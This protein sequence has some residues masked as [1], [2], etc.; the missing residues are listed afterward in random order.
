MDDINNIKINDNPKEDS[1]INN[2]K[3][4]E[5]KDLKNIDNQIIIENNQNKDYKAN[6]N[7]RDINNGNKEEIPIDKGVLENKEKVEKTNFNIKNNNELN[8]NDFKE[9]IHIKDQ[10]DKDENND[11]KQENQT[12]GDERTKNVELQNDEK[13]V[14]KQIEDE[15]NNRIQ[16]QKEKFDSVKQENINENIDKIIQQ[17]NDIVPKEKNTVNDENSKKEKEDLTL[18]NFNSNSDL[19][20]GIPKINYEDEEENQKIFEEMKYLKPSELFNQDKQKENDN[21]NEL[22][23]KILENEEEIKKKEKEQEEIEKK[24]NEESNILKFF[25]KEEK[26]RRIK[27]LEQYSKNTDSLLESI[28]NDWSSGD[29]NGFTTRYE[30]KYINDMNNLFNKMNEDISI[31]DE[32]I[33]K[34]FKFICDYLQNRKSII[35]EIPWVE[36]NN[37][38]KI[39]VRDNFEGVCILNNDNLLIKQYEELLFCYNIENSNEKILEYNNNIF[40]KYLMEFLFKTGFFESFLEKVYSR[41]DEIYYSIDENSIPNEFSSF[42]DDFINL[43]C[44]PFEVFNYCT[45]EYLIKN[46]YCQKFIQKFIM[47]IESIIK[48][49]ALN[50]E[51]KKKFYNAITEK[52]RAFIGNFF[53]YFDDIK[54]KNNSDWEKFAC[55]VLII[56]ENYLTKQKLESRIYGLN[57]VSQLTDVFKHENNS[58]E[59]AK[60][61]SFVK[62][63][64]IKY[65]NKINIYNLIFGENIHEALVHRAYNL[66][67]FLYKNKAFNK[68][69]IKHLWILS[70]DK[71]QTISDNIIELFGKLLPEFS[72]DDSNEILKI[73]SEMN[74]SEVNEV[75]LKLLENFFNS[76]EK[77]EKLYKILFKFSDELTLNDGLSKSIILKSRNILVKLLFNQIYIK[78][79]INTIKKCIFNI[80]KNYLVN[81]SLSILK[82]IIDEFHRNENSQG[83]RI[84]FSEINPNIFSLDLLI[85]FLEKKGNLF[86]VLFTNILDNIYLIQFLLE[87]TKNLNHLLNSNENFD[88]ELSLKLDEMYKKFIDPENGYYYN[89]GLNGHIQGQIINVNPIR[90]LSNNQLDKTQSTEKSLNEGL[91]GDED[92]NDGNNQNIINNNEDIFNN[93]MGNWEFEINP[94]KYFKNIFKEY[95]LF[96][97]KVSKKNNFVFFS[98]KELI[99]YIF[100]KFEFPFNNKNHYQNLKELLDIIISFFVLGKIPIQIGY[101]KYLYDILINCSVTNQ[102][103]II[104]YKFLNDILKKQSENQNILIISDKVLTE[105][106]LDKLQK[107]DSSSINQLPYEAFEFFKLFIIY[108]NQKH[109]NIYYS[110]ATKKIVSIQKY[111]LLAGI[112]ILENYYIYSKDETIFNESL[113]LLT[114]ILSVASEKLINRKKILDKIFTFLKNNLNKIKNDNE[115]KTQI[116]REIKLISIINSTKVKDIYDENDKNN[117]IQINVI[118]KL[119]KE[120]ED[121]LDIGQIKVSKNMKIKELKNEIMNKVILTEKNIKLYNQQNNIEGISIFFTADEIR[122]E[123]N[124]KGISLKFQNQDLDETSSLNDFNINNDDYITITVSEKIYNQIYEIQNEI[125]ISEERLN[126]ECEKIKGI[127]SDLDKEIIKLAIKKNRGNAEDTTMFLTEENNINIIKKEIEENKKKEKNELKK[128]AKKEQDYI[129]ALEEDRINLLFD[130]LNQEDNLINEEIWKLLSSIKYPDNLIERATSEE[131]MKI[132]DEPNLYKMLLNIKLVNSLVFDDK[133][134]KFNK[135]STEKKLNWTSKLIKNESFVNSILKKMDKI[136]EFQEQNEIIEIKEKNEGKKNEDKIG[137]NQVIKFQILSIFTNWFHNIFINMIDLIKNDYIHNIINDI[138]QCNSFTLNNQINNENHNQR[139]NLNNDNNEGIQEKLEAINEKDVNN[140]MDILDKNNIIKLFYQITKVSLNITKDYKDIIKLVLEM[141]LIYFSINKKSITIFLEEEKNNKIFSYLMASEKNKDIRTMVLNFLKILVKN[142]NN[143]EDREKMKCKDEIKNDEKKIININEI[144]DKEISERKADI[145]NQQIEIKEKEI[146]NNAKNYQINRSIIENEE[147]QKKEESE[148]LNMKKSEEEKEKINKDEKNER[149]TKKIENL[150]NID[151]NKNQNKLDKVVEYDNINE[152][153]DYKLKKK[154]LKPLESPNKVQKEIEKEIKVD[155]QESINDNENLLYKILLDLYKDKIFSE[156]LFN[157]EFYILYSFLIQFKEIFYKEEEKDNFFISKEIAFFILHIHKYYQLEGEE[158]SKKKSNMMYHIYLLSSCFKYYSSLIKYHMQKNKDFNLISILYN[159]LFEVSKSSNN[160]ILYK[161]DWDNLRKHAYNLLSN[162]IFLDI[163]YMNRWLPKI[164]NYRHIMSQEK[165]QIN[166]DFKLRDPTYDKLIGLKNFGAT[167][168]LNSLFQQM[169]MNPLFS[170]DLLSFDFSEKNDFD[171]NSS[172]LYNMQL[173]FVN[174]RYSCLGVYPPLEFIKSFK[175]AFNGQPIQFGVQQDSDEFLSILCDELEKEAKLFNKENFLNNSFKGQISNEIVSLNKEYPYYSKT[176]EDFYRVTLD[177]KGHKTLEEALDAYIKGEI[178]DGDNQYYVEKYNKKLP[179]RKSS[180]LKILGNQVIIHLKRFEFDFVTFTNKKLNDYLE[181]PFEI[182]FKK[183]T[184]AFLRSTDPN[185]KPELLN[186]TEDEKDNLDE[187]K[188]NYVL[189]GILIHS[190]SSLQSGHYYSLINDQESGKWYQFNDN[191]ISEFNIEKDLEK[192]CFGIKGKIEGEQFGRTAYLLFYTKKSL[193][194]NEKILEGIKINQDLINKVHKEN[195]KYLEIKTYSS[196][197]YHEFLIKLINNCFKNLKDTNN[198]IE[199]SIN[200]KLRERAKIFEAIKNEQQNNE[201]ENINKIEDERDEKKSKSEVIIPD[202]IEEIIKTI[203]QKSK[204]KNEIN[205][206]NFINKKAIKA[207]VYYIFG[208]ATKYF[209]NNIKISSI[210]NTLNGY[211]STNKIYCITIL[212]SIENFLEK[213]VDYLFKIG[214]KSQDMQNINKEIFDLFKNLFENVYIYE[215]ENLKLISRKFTYISKNPNN[216]KYEITQ[217]YESCLFRIVKNLFCKN[218]EK[219]RLEYSKDIMFL[220]L[221]R[222]CSGSFP[223]ISIILEDYLIP[224]ISFITNNKLSE[225]YLKSKINPGFHM[226]GNPNWKPN[227]NYE[228]IFTDI[229]LHS[230]NEGMYKTK[231]LSPYFIKDNMN[232]IINKKSEII[233]DEVFDYYP[234]LPK[235]LV[236]M[237]SPLF[238]YDFLASKNCTIEVLGNLCYENEQ[239]SK[240]FFKKINNYFRDINREFGDFENIFNKACSILKLDDSLNELRLEKLFELGSDNQQDLPIFDFYDHIKE[241]YDIVLDF[242][243]MLATAMYE[244]NSLY[245][246]LFKYKTKITWIYYYFNK[247]KNDGMGTKTFNALYSVHPEFIEIIEEGL[248]NRLEL[249]PKI[250]TDNFGDEDGFNLI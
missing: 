244:Y 41:D 237:L 45:K 103:K 15:L 170:R 27:K 124:K 58:E 193:Y 33:C 158:F 136:V 40:F 231:K 243:Y 24:I 55:Y 122:Q 129:I 224:L 216:N 30:Y 37:I 12:K 79:L 18:Q 205:I 189:T 242:I 180:S 238:I 147:S 160:I 232:Y 166:F 26:E 64:I 39:L 239:F 61:L 36:M 74:L 144:N 78:D 159:C 133:F 110:S 188:M 1:E 4:D 128:K 249:K 131:L 9:Y 141:Q 213:I 29:R 75:T 196:N 177:I 104:Y 121:I 209:D 248:I 145:M 53:N 187:E 175:K 130:L 43:I 192:E 85:K 6:M 229:I 197:L 21:E 223:E 120:N 162:I 108:F 80:G 174:L 186:I 86:S 54:D 8:P 2:Q 220:H 163:E 114:N 235:N 125:Q 17:E 178:L 35:K 215:K 150:D 168:Y 233:G 11:K 217:E 137:E 117:M 13:D 207:L 183:W 111:E 219:C 179:I 62:E 67:S 149:S 119:I 250:E 140:F 60:K 143:F 246:Y 182:N 230:I 73:V 181:F 95:I 200:K 106:I 38:R 236:A 65:M 173:G 139:N 105:L 49:S 204:E 72:I 91:L 88:S 156:E 157:H 47:K 198:E 116:I 184:R 203:E 7:E 123:F 3:N 113:D 226:G 48:S 82:L 57:L 77:N 42:F 225:P 98:E 71:Y 51:F 214:V 211:I 161:F 134:C 69:Q 234:K 32:I 138:K 59:Y 112:H 22:A 191:N 221:L 165:L 212:K 208:I 66:L 126:E 87:E 10:V 70:Q 171:L 118:N 167:C 99:D 176:D 240:L 194:R 25:E 101:F 245:E 68:E 23:R 94:E 46:N 247:I 195:I 218:L 19:K 14:E 56:A 227:E 31:K 16:D 142:L 152:I 148:D 93:E 210:L 206:K 132:I 76:K 222:F 228:I 127:F 190:G 155:N 199:Y 20:E 201:I 92:D 172:V 63:S 153:N 185:L 115:I 169:F 28:I 52:Y 50:E 109:G 34:I 97:K 90:Q 81:T 154:D 83:V 107:Y 5:N 102:E 96:I 89:Y 146:S 84:I 241:K 151:I 202:N 164:L 135:I 44:Y 100:N